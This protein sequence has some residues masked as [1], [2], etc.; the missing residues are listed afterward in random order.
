MSVLVTGATGMIGSVLT[1]RLVE[2]GADVRVLYRTDARL[3]NLGEIRKNVNAVQGDVL[4]PASLLSAMEGV[5][6]IYHVAAM[7]GYG[8]KRHWPL[9][10]RVNVQG[11]GN[12]VDAALAVGIRRMV[13]TSSIAAIGRPDA[14]DVLIDESFEWHASRANTHYARSKHLAELEIHRGIAEGLDAVLVNPT[15]VFGI[16]RR[17]ENTR[18]LVDQIRKR[19]LPVMP[20]GGT[21]FVDAE[22]VVEGH[23]LAMERGRTGERYILGSENLLWRTA[24]EQIADAFGVKP[25]P[26]VVPPG[27]ALAVGTVVEG[28]SS[29]IPLNPMISRETARMSA[30]VYRYDNSRAQEELGCSFRP[31]AE[32]AA[33]IASA[34][35]DA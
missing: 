21:N 33:R 3:E 4:D 20:S 30:R 6:E 5:D 7:I 25:P 8:G 19:R 29:V 32:T 11:T 27:V 24:F 10:R 2:R 13:H 18:A 16:G 31:F 23:L 28:I 12:V 17:G 1:R 9:L 26:F 22:D 14:D 35:A 34:L 15:I